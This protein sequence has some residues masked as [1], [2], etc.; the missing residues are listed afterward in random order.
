MRRLLPL[1]LLL[2]GLT[3][4]VHAEGQWVGQPAPAI[5]LPDQDGKVRQLSEFHGQWIALYFYPKDN[6]PGCTQEAIR[7]RERW[8][9]L[10]KAN[11]MVIGVSVDDVASHKAFATRLQLPY[12]LLADEAHTLTKAMG[13][14]KGF[15]PVSYAS[16]ETFLI[17]PEGTIV[18]HYP[19]V[20]TGRHAAQVLADVARLSAPKAP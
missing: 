19:D 16:R 4:T 12:P 1:L 8:S 7:F 5:A 20:D 10:R 13:V 6:T 18:Y 11:I 14:L 3:P 17:D 2:L 9:E 15:G